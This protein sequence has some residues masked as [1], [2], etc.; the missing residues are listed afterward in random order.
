MANNEL[1]TKILEL[2][3]VSRTALAGQQSVPSRYDRIQY[4]KKPLV[5]YNSD[6]LTHIGKGKHLW[7][8]IEEAIS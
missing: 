8:A 3:H 1:T 6:M 7:F 2:W 4:V 5:E